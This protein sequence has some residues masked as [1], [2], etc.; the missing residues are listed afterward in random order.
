MVVVLRG[1][2]TFGVKARHAQEAGAAAMIVVN[3]EGGSRVREYL[4]KY[5][6]RCHD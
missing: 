3:E 6:S 1:L 4:K 5:I 2:V